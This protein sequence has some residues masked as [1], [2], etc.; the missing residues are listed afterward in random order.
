MA[1]NFVKKFQKKKVVYRSEMARNAIK[2]EFRTSKMGAGGDFVNKINKV[3]YWS[4]M[5]INAAE[6]DLRTTKMAAAA[7]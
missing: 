1:R 2:S 4:E 5:A 6:S 7:I 3:S